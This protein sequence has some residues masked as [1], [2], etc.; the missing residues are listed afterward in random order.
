MAAS[1][2]L[3]IFTRACVIDE[4]LPH[5]ACTHTEE[6]CPVLES[7]IVPTRKSNVDFVDQCSGLQCVIATFASHVAG[8]PAVSR[9][10]EHNRPRFFLRGFVTVSPL[11]E[12]PRHID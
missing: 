2:A 9:F 4:N 6:M 8:V 3:L 12:Q 7:S 5:H 10:C 1:A 11:L